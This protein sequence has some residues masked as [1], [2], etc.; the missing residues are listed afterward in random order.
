MLVTVADLEG[1][2]RRFEA[3]GV[4]AA[5]MNGQVRLVTHADLSDADIGTALDRIGSAAGSRALR[6]AGPVPTRPAGH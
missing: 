4:R 1:T 2:L 6:D 3:A 5:P